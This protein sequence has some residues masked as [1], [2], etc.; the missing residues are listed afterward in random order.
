MKKKVFLSIVCFCAAY[1]VQA[2]QQKTNNPNKV[3]KST[4]IESAPTPQPAIENTNPKVKTQAP[5]KANLPQKKGETRAPQ[6]KADPRLRVKKS[7]PE[8]I[9]PVVKP[10]ESK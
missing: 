8:T 4:K 7:K 3:V 10:A 6:V 2:Q 9:K 5:S 1:A